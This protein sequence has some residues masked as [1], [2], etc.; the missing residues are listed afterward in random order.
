MLQKL[1]LINIHIK[2]YWS[3]KLR[4]DGMSETCNTHEKHSKCSE[5][6]S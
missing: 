4:V 1:G 3:D 5:N 2:Y 6:F